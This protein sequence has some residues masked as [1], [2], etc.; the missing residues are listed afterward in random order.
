M[1]DFLI[2][3]HM[4][5]Y[6]GLVFLVVCSA[7][8]NHYQ[9][10]RSSPLNSLDKSVL[11]FAVVCG[12]SL[13][14]PYSLPVNH[15]KRWLLYYTG[16]IET[17]SFYFLIRYLL[18]R[19][20]RFLNWIVLAVVL[21]TFASLVIAV[22]EIIPLGLDIG[23]IFVTRMK[24][25]FGYHNMNL[26]GIQS[27]LV[28]PIVAY[29]LQDPFLQRWRAFLWLSFL[30]LIGLSILTLNRGTFAVMGLELLLLYTMQENKRI[31]RW[32]FCA[33]LVLAGFFNK[34]IG[35]YVLRFIAGSGKST[36]VMVIDQSALYRLEAWKTG[37]KSLFLYPFGVGG[38][39][40]QY[41]W[42]MYGTDPHFYLGTPHQLFLSI[43]VDYG[44][45]ALIVFLTIL[46][47]VFSYTVEI[48]RS[49]RESPVKRLFKYLAISF[50]GFITY[51]L[52]SDG[53]LSHLSG[54]VT[55]NNGYSLIFFALLATA[56]V[57]Y[58]RSSQMVIP[59]AQGKN[60]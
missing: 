57:C 36:E 8:L 49:L 48:A 60:S 11:L 21:T 46:F 43:G 41:V 1:G 22:I 35:F 33:G 54:F 19:R 31:L 28:L 3:P 24:I 13:I 47:F 44:L 52:I 29:A 27:V 6:V 16:V 34:L 4:V 17:V 37:F 25:G 30:V 12:F 26:F 39:G 7:A 50:I 59:R 14:Y 15:T 10:D 55:P 42:H 23:R 38:G 18:W 58:S 56:S 40:F 53:E 51:G 2:T 45:A 5:I 9:S 32:L 20:I